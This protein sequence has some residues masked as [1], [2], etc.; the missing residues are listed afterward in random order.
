MD[1]QVPVFTQNVTIHYY[2]YILFPQ[3]APD[4]ARWN[5]FHLAPVSFGCVLIIL[6]ALLYFEA[7]GI[8]DSFCAFPSQT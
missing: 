8:L 3:L 2:H 7:Q 5:A 6:C 4:M 1:L